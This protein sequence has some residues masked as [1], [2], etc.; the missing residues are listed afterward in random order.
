M[1]FIKLNSARVRGGNVTRFT[2]LIFIYAVLLGLDSLI[3]HFFVDVRDIELLKPA[4]FAGI[5]FLMG[6]LSTRKD[7]YTFAKHAATALALVA[8]IT[9]L[10]GVLNLFPE[11]GSLNYVAIVKTVMAALSITFIIVAVQLFAAERK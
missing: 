1:F 9:S 10:G 11:D 3:V 7:M 2:K 4:L 8:F 5:I 6:Y